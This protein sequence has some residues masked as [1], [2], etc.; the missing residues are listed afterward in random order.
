MALEAACPV[1]DP[2][3]D[4]RQAM[5]VEAKAMSGMFRT[6]VGAAKYLSLRADEGNALTVGII[7]AIARPYLLREERLWLEIMTAR[8]DGLNRS[9][10]ARGKGIDQPTLRRSEASKSGVISPSPGNG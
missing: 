2:R 7:R 8:I 10:H 4:L 5:I 1:H 3:R 6:G 9:R